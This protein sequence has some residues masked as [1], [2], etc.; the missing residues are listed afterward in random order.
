M[1]VNIFFFFRLRFFRWASTNPVRLRLHVW[2]V[3]LV[4]SRTLLDLYNVM[5]VSQ[6]RHLKQKIAYVA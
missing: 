3:L 4:D 6:E 2:I 1:M 5:T